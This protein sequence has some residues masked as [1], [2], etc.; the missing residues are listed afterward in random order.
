MSRCIEC[1]LLAGSERVPKWLFAQQKGF[2]NAPGHSGGRW[3]VIQD[4][5]QCHCDKF[6]QAPQDKINQRRKAVQILRK[7]YETK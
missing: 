4:I 7:R 5:E 2:C 6:K 3:N 1:E